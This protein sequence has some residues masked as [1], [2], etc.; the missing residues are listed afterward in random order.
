MEQ[1]ERLGCYCTCPGERVQGVG[2]GEKR[3][4]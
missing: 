1:E 2:P 4:K 3:E